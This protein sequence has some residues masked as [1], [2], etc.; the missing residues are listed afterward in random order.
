MFNP[1]WL[2]IAFAPEETRDNS[3]PL[4]S[5]DEVT[6]IPVPPIKESAVTLIEAVASIPETFGETIERLPVGVNVPIPTFPLKRAA[7]V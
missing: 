3:F 2:L 7:L 1:V 6:N 4:D 5:D